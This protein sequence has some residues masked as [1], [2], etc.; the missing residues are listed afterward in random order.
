V[1]HPV[2]SRARVDSLKADDNLPLLHETAWNSAA[3][4]QGVPVWDPEKKSRNTELIGVQ[5]FRFFAGSV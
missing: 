2:V 1:L 4:T 5:V 3:S